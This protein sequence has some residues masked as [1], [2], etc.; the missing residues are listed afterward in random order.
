MIITLP[1][2]LYIKREDSLQTT[3]TTTSSG[4]HKLVIITLFA[5]DIQW[6]SNDV[7]VVNYNNKS[8]AAAK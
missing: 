7:Q 4:Q 5:G 1:I 8:I 6:G 2:S 3:T